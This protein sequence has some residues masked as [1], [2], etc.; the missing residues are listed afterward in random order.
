MASPHNP[1]IR[2]AFASPDVEFDVNQNVRPV[3]FD[4]LAP[5]LET[6]VLPDGLKM[7]LAV[8]PANMSISYE[9][10]ITRIQTKGGF[11]EQ[12]WGDGARSISFSS[13][14]GGFK[15]LYSGL[16]N[17][18]EGYG[19]QDLGGTR[20]ETINYDKYL[21][22][23]TLF[24]NNGSVFDQ[25]G[26]V[27][28]QGIIKVVFDGASYLGWFNSFSVQEAADKPYLFNVNMDMTIAHE[29]MQLRSLPYR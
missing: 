19:G 20:R 11:V 28:F 15:R 1:I 23:L 2:M 18:T 12:H 27:V 9:K 3:V 10:V 22:L 16:S 13:V 5:D 17:V 21:D 4:V 25:R 7:V 6:S 14:T 24:H 26:Q 8:N 29:V